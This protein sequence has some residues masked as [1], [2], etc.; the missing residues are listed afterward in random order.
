MPRVD[1]SHMGQIAHPGRRRGAACAVALGVTLAASPLLSGCSTSGA[2]ATTTLRGA[3]SA[4]VVHADGTTVP[5]LDGLRLRRADVV[6][7]A[8]GGRAELVTGSRTVY[9]GSE[10]AVEVDDG[11][12]QQ[13]RT[14]AV[15][16]DAQHG[17]PLHLQVGGLD[18]FT[19]A[20]AA[21][22]AERG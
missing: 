15:V 14:G 1:H 21:V 9:V 12:H 7:T 19:P 5:G 4:V 8:P 16:A 22:R 10:A 13:L 11:A 18:V 6:H 2:A 17:S 20:G 3:L